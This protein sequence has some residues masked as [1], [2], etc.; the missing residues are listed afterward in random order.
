MAAS[1]QNIHTHIHTIT[2][3]SLDFRLRNALNQM[4]FARRLLHRRLCSPRCRHRL[5]QS[6]AAA[7]VC[8]RRIAG[9]RHS[10]FG[11]QRGAG[12]AARVFVPTARIH[13][14][15]ALA[16]LHTLVRYRRCWLLQHGLLQRD[17]TAHRILA[18]RSCGLRQRC[19]AA[20]RARR[21]RHRTIVERRHLAARRFT[22]AT[23]GLVAV[24]V[25]VVTRAQRMILDDTAADVIHSGRMHTTAAATVQ[26]VRNLIVFVRIDENVTVIEP[27]RLAFGIAPENAAH[28]HDDE[29]KHT[30]GGHAPECDLQ[31][32][33]RLPPE[34][35]RRRIC[36]HEPPDNGRQVLR[37]KGGLGLAIV[38]QYGRVVGG[39]QIQVA[40]F[41]VARQIVVQAKY[42]LRCG[43]SASNQRLAT[44]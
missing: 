12:R 32:F 21:T 33:A 23:A 30:G 3:G 35:R 16:E 14:D 1:V 20:H 44:T 4:R 43:I 18:A 27:I 29:Q 34:F 9:R 42:L 17:G 19:Q 31:R 11:R 2:I 6:S 22:T 38:E 13:V 40:Q 41:A 28:H 24:L 10:R 15:A 36:R 25:H 39:V 8:R 37:P 7:A 5:C 26:R